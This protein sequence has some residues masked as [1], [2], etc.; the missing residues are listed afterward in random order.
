MSGLTAFVTWFASHP[1]VRLL[2]GLAFLAL[3]GALFFRFTG[4]TG[5]VIFALLGLG[6]AGLFYLSPAA[7]LLAWLALLTLAAFTAWRGA[8]QSQ[9]YRPAAAVVE[10]GGIRRGLTPAEAALVL[11]HPLSIALTAVIVDLLVKEVFRLG[12]GEALA[13]EVAEPYRLDVDDPEAR[14]LALRRVA[15]VH[16]VVLYP[17]EEPFLAVL[18]QR[19]GEPLAQVNLTAAARAL[20]RHTARRVRGYDLPATQTYYRQHLGRARHDLNLARGT[21]DEARLRGRNLGWA[22]LDPQLA[23]LYG[24]FWPPGLSQAAEEGDVLA[25]MARLEKVLSTAV[26]PGALVTRTVGGQRLAIG[27]RDA[28][29]AAFLEAEGSQVTV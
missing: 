8:G 1:E 14:A 2:A 19:Q 4:G 28:V 16:N 17:Y 18:G 6:L 3:F 12:E 7:H 9:E 20:I 26:P 5:K 24:E 25:W 13:L 29:A 23:T 21:P 11:G 15:Q 27:G 22:L 10:G